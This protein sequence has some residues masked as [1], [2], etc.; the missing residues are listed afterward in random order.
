MDTK[1]TTMRGDDRLAR[2]VFVELA[3]GIA[4][5]TPS[6]ALRRSMRARVLRR[7]NRNAAPPGTWT[8]HAPDSRWR[9]LAPGVDFR[10]MRVD[11]ATGRMTAFVRMRSG[12]RFDAHEHTSAESCFVVEGGI[13]IG[14]LTLNRGD[15]HCAQAG[16]RHEPTVSDHGALL[17]V[18]GAVPAE[19]CGA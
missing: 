14:A 12:S 4:A 11:R 18:H 1:I 13:R 5:R 16:T 17:V 8:V 10:I 6:R 9:E 3:L 19:H 15:L 2:A 7:V